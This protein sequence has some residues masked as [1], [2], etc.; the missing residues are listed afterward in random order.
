MSSSQDM[1]RPGEPLDL[2]YYSGETSKK[3]AW[4]TTQ[5]TKYQVNFNNT[6]AGTSSFLFPPQCGLQDIV[7]TMQFAGIPNTAENLTGLALPA[8]WGYG[9]IKSCAF[10]Y[11][12]TSQF[13][14]SGDQLLQNALRDQTSRT[15]CDDIVNIGGNYA[16]G[17]DLVNTQT[18]SIVLRLPHASASGVNKSLPF[19]TDCL[20]QQC[21]VL[22]E[23]NAPASVW[24]N[25]STL[26]LPSQCLQLSQ[27]YFQCQQ[28]M[29]NNMG[30]SL[31]RRVDLSSKAYAFP[32]EFV[33]Q[34]SIINLVNST[35]PQSVVLTGFRAGSVKSIQVW[36]TDLADVQTTSL[37]SSTGFNP[38][39]LQVPTSVEMLYAGDIYARYNNGVGQLFNLI[40]GNKASAFDLA[41]ISVGAGPTVDAPLPYLSQWLELPFAQPLCDEDAHYILMHGRVITNGIINL[42]N[43]V[44]PYTSPVGWQL[45]IS[46]VYTA[47]LLFSQG[48]CD[49]VF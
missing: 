5:N 2:Y 23:L 14:L 33:Q 26:A 45:N 16:S 38:N 36:L 11:G 7:V 31:A 13:V 8:G 40:N 29:F 17:L 21:Q 32:C 19:P 37:G 30:D 25:V 39:K 28:V 1:V 3:S 9:L 22:L 4:P 18:A 24:T 35:A 27:G 46:Y 44:V 41:V 34:K 43:L 10:R 47:T 48:S 12:G 15:S 49:Y 6:G 20:T 42:N